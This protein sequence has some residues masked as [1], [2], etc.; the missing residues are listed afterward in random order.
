[1]YCI[2]IYITLHI[3]SIPYIP[4]VLGFLHISSVYMY[5]CT[6]IQRNELAFNKNVQFLQS[7]HMGFPH[8]ILAFSQDVMVC[9]I[10]IMVVVA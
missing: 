10:N 6:C 2:Y 7:E 8:R 1:M 4:C 9:K 5:I 3:L